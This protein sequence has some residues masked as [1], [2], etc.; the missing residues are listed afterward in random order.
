MKQPEKYDIFLS[1]RR[2]GGMETAML[3]RNSLEKKGYRVF[4]DIDTL[5]AGPFNEVLYRVIENTKDFLLVLPPHALDRCENE[6]DWVRLE[7]EHAKKCEKNIVPIMLK[8]F[9]FPSQLPE[10]IEFIRYQNG[11]RATTEYYDA[12]IDKLTK[13]LNSRRHPIP[14]WLFAVLAVLLIATAAFYLIRFL[15]P[16]IPEQVFVPGESNVLV[17]DDYITEG[18]LDKEGSHSVFRF[19]NLTRADIATITFLDSLSDV[20]AD[21]VDFSE[22]MDGSVL[23]WIKKSTG[24]LYDLYIGGINGV[25]APKNCSGL[26]NSY[27]N[28]R[29]IDFGNA[30]FTDGATNFLQMF[31]YCPK[32]SKLDLQGFNTKNV[33]DMSGMF[34]HNGSLKQIIFAEG[35]DTS[36]VTSMTSMFYGCKSLEQLDVS[37]FHTQNVTSMHGMFLGC[38][39]LSALDV[40]G[41]DTSKVVYMSSMFSGCSSQLALDVSGFD[42]S[43]VKNMSYMFNNCSS[44]PNLDVSGFDTSKVADMSYMFSGCSSLSNLDISD[45][46]VSNVTTMYAMFNNCSSLSN[47]DVSGF[48]TSKVTNMSFMFNNCS[49]L[50]N[51]DVS[52]FDTSNVIDYDNFMPD[53]LNPNWR[54]MF[55]K[56]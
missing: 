14:N 36:N 22:N 30:F 31:F 6:S 5:R 51:L 25:S 39:Q 29:R 4:L 55:Q 46:N 19:E 1:Y 26:F 41:F 44:L 33:T 12:F 27:I 9:E 13:F 7:I 23:G 37:N 15:N 42:T 18:D 40:S 10:S 17:V 45:F 53:N 32:L 47:L 20:P 49:R 34:C 43:K 54:E 2:E 24:G 35:F 52:G 28:L 3:L 8:G 48:D 16:P 21:A 11:P 50:S 38:G 56:S